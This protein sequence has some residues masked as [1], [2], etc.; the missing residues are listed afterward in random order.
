MGGVG[1]GGGAAKPTP[2]AG[3]ATTHPSTPTPPPTP[4]AAV[5]ADKW[6]N[7][8]VKLP[9]S[10]ESML[11]VKDGQGGTDVVPR[12]DLIMK[13]LETLASKVGWSSIFGQQCVVCLR[14][15][16]WI[17]HACSHSAAVRW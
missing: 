6:D 9:C 7:D 15:K 10:Q 16:D 2:K 17:A 5:A 1:G 13:A 8:H 14:M 4:F 12:W 3:F 11:A